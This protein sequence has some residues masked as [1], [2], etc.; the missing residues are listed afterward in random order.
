M[1]KAKD[2]IGSRYG[3]LLV[4]SRDTEPSKYAHARWLCVCDCGNTT[5]VLSTN[6]RRGS[7]TSCGCYKISRIVETNTKH[8]RTGSAELNT[9][10]GM[11]SRCLNAK[12][13][14]FKR[15][16]GRGITVCDRWHRDTPGAFENFLADMGERPSLEH[17]I[18]RMDNDGPYSPENCRWAV[19]KT[20][21]NNKRSNT[22]LT[23][24]GKAQ[25]VTQWAEELG[26]KRSKIYY[27]LRRG[28]SV[29]DALS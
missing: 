22:I 19:Q 18:D 6:L 16:G 11:N 13:K 8:G 7:T 28:W 29:E 12:G 15:Y 17:S 3:R 23:F 14:D 1:A 4:V 5:T 26:M 24:G 2:E 20:Q 27:R 10:M 25:N 21:Q 9:F